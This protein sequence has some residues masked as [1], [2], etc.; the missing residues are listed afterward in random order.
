MEFTAFCRLQTS[1]CKPNVHTYS[2]LIDACSRAA[3]QDLAIRV[4]HK[5]MMDGVC[6]NLLVYTVAISACRSPQHADLKTA[7]QIYKDLR[8]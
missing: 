7:M 8:R 5:A 2:S 4:Y 6:H 3:E 1:G